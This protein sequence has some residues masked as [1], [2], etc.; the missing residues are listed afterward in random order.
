[1][2]LEKRWKNLIKT[3]PGEDLNAYTPTPEYKAGVFIPR[4]EFD[5]LFRNSIH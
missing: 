3:L 2:L 1:M 5:V 4:M